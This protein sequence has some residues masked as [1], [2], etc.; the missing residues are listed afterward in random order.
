MSQLTDAELRARDVINY[1]EHESRQ[2]PIDTYFIQ[3]ILAKE[4]NIVLN[5]LSN[6]L[7]AERCEWLGRSDKINRITQGIIRTLCRDSQLQY[8]YKAPPVVVLKAPSNIKINDDPC[9]ICLTNQCTIVTPCNHQF[10]KD[11]LMQNITYSKLCP[12]C[13]TRFGRVY[14]VSERS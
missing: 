9:S 6:Y 7:N 5:V 4:S 8:T 1:I 10:C 3:R 12:M 14:C 2:L 11:C 13:R